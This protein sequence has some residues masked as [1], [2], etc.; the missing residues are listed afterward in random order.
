MTPPQDPQHA[1]VNAELAARL[2]PLF[3]GHHAR[4][5]MPLECGH[6]SRP[7]PDLAIVRGRPLDWASGHP[8]GGD[9]A[10]VVE[11]ARTSHARDA[12]KASIYAAAGTPEYWILDLVARRLQVHTE[13]G[14]SGYGVVTI[15]DE[16]HATTLADTSIRVGELLPK[17]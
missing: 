1:S 3:P 6:A 5:G 7:E 8:A 11:V 12:Y 2:A 4:T 17:A 10:L 13:P 9:T 15:L 14:P 16:H